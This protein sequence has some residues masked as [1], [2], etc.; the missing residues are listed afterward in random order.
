MMGELEITVI[1]VRLNLLK[2]SQLSKI[3]QGK[4]MRTLMECG[5]VKRRGTRMVG[6]AFDR[7]LTTELNAFFSLRPFDNGRGCR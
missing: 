4:E 2:Q 6:P 3:A 1:F 7:V 5:E